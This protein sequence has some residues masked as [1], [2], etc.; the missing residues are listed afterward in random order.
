MFPFSCNFSFFFSGNY[1]WAPTVMSRKSISFVRKTV[2]VS[3]LIAKNRALY[4]AKCTSCRCNN[5]CR[6]S[7]LFI[8]N[9]SVEISDCNLRFSDYVQE[10]ENHWI[11]TISTGCC[12]A[13]LR[14]LFI[15]IRYV[16][17]RSSFF[18]CCKSFEMH[19]KP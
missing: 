6:P 16:T 8:V 10:A 1:L 9:S 18:N 4:D 2:A 19:E 13:Y 15:C 5:K 12:S 7:L 17:T 14:V 11:A 3:Q